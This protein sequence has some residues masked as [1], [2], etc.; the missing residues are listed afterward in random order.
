MNNAPDW[1][2]TEPTRAR[3]ACLNLTSGDDWG[4]LGVLP[5][6]IKRT[7]AIPRLQTKS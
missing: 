4:N 6:F 5:I 2:K 3:E 7:I 1:P